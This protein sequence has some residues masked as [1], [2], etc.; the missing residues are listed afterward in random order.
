MSKRT[1]VVVGGRRWLAPDLPAAV[2]RVAVAGLIAAGGSIGGPGVV[3]GAAQPPAADGG[4]TADQAAA[5]WSVYARQCGECHGAGLNGAEAPALRGVDFLN[6]WAGETTDELFAYVRDE[7]PPGLGGSLGE[8]VYLN[9]VA[10]IL[11]MNG[12]RPG[13]APLTADAAVAIGDAADVAEARRAARAGERPR[14]RPT[15]FVNRE[16][17]HDLTPVTE[18]LLA[19]P[20]P[21]DWLSW[22]RTRDG[23]GYSPLDRV[24]RDNVDELRLAWVLAIREGNHQTAPLVHDGVMFLASPGDVVQALDAVAGDVIWQYRSPLPEDAP[25]RAP[26]RTLALYGDKVFLATADAAIVALDARTGEVVWRTVKDDY[27]QGFRQNAG[28]V[29][30]DGVVVTGTNGCQ[31]YKAQTCF[32]T[33]HDPDTGEELWRTSTIA[34]PGDPNDASWGDTPPYLRAGGDQWIPGSYDPDLG[35]YYIGTAQAK[36]WVAASRGMNDAAG[37]ALHQLDAGPEPADRAG[38]RGTSSTRRAR[39]STST[40]CTSGCWSTPTAKSGG[41]SRSGRT[42]SSGSSTGGP[43]R[44]STC[45]RRSTRTSSS[46]STGRPGGSRTDR[47]SVTPGH[48]RPRPG[49]SQS[50]RR[51]QLAGVGVPPRAP[52]RWSF[53]CTRR[54]CT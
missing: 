16:V 1:R 43:A 8:Q 39:P 5:G 2:V 33:G 46:R 40:S 35:L 50:A 30:A 10:Y 38:R 44:S 42:A 7:M 23:H 31:R 51:A 45:A 3:A 41:S 12:A 53:R 34:L 20:S 6:G 11:D 49:L 13:D 28:P 48:R 25:Q 9:L 26:T 14:R 18:A 52:G 24:T 27:T 21:G 22:R 17:P 29:I 32:I 47:T 54:A 19:D 4:F 36:P 15:R 37:R